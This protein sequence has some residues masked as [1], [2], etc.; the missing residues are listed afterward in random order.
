MVTRAIE[1]AAKHGGY[2]F[3]LA[4]RPGTKTNQ[5]Q[6]TPAATVGVPRATYDAVA[7]YDMALEA[8]NLELKMDGGDRSSADSS[9]PVTLVSVTVTSTT[10]AALVAEMKRVQET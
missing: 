2:E 1:L 9:L 6:P 4:L 10:T 7:E 5:G 3:A 8:K